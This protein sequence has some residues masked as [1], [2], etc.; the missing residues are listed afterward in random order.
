MT[1]GE[2]I[3]AAAVNFF[4]GCT[5]QL[6]T[7]LHKKAAG[8]AA[9]R[10]LW[11]ERGKSFEQRISQRL[12]LAIQ[13]AKLQPNSTESLRAIL[14]DQVV[15]SETVQAF[16]NGRLTV[17]AFT[18]IIAFRDPSLGAQPA[19]TTIGETL[20][21]VYTAAVATDAELSR[22]VTL[23]R[24]DA[25]A[26]QVSEVHLELQQQRQLLTELAKNSA[27][28]GQPNETLSESERYERAITEVASAHKLSVTQ[29]REAISSFSSRVSLDAGASDLDQAL[30]K[31]GERDFA[32]AESRAEQ[33]VQS[34]AKA[35]EHAMDNK[36]EAL[37]LLG[38]IQMAQLKYSAAENSYRE[39]Y[40]IAEQQDILL[41]ADV[42][43]RLSRLLGQL[44]RYDE[45]VAIATPFLETAERNFG[46]AG[47]MVA[48]NHL[49]SRYKGLVGTN[50]PSRFYVGLS[51]CGN[52]NRKTRT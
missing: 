16:L 31:V 35:A 42:G 6:L 49:G 22:I 44:G 9:D 45:A 4:T 8:R 27:L 33:A 7:E 26:G 29:L 50:R 40:A 51:S 23:K 5:Q 24:S 10:Q 13:E 30:A 47:T 11:R 36:R 28:V 48:L 41:A 32:D 21:D 3:T 52:L 12:V 18:E 39:A 14:S 43:W 34:A 20:V 19:V 46:R 15:V 25:L 37:L 1:S 17:E 38:D 2:L